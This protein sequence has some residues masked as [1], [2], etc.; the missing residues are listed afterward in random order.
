ML[1]HDE[2][3]GG[4]EGG[5]LDAA[6]TIADCGPALG[7]PPDEGSAFEGLWQIV[8]TDM[9]RRLDALDADAARLLARIKTAA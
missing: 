7:V 2:G 6:K 9:D 8:L 3:C 5:A 4:S 1:N